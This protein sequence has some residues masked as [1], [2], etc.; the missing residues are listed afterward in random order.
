MSGRVRVPERRTKK[1]PD[2]G[3]I[4]VTHFVLAVKGFLKNNYLIIIKVFHSG[5]FGISAA[6]ISAATRCVAAE[7]EEARAG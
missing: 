2:R 4:I 6:E 1:A 7:K 5:S 3:S